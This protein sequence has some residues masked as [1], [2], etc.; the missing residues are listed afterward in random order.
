[1]KKL[2]ILLFSILISFNSY[3]EE[4]EKEDVMETCSLYEELAGSIMT[5][6]QSGTSISKIMKIVGN[7]ELLQKMIVMAY[8]ESRW[9]VED[10]QKKSIENFKNKWFLMCFKSADNK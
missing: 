5:H 10:N 4:T 8:E 9:G 3:A 6:R 1:M 2:T 7:D